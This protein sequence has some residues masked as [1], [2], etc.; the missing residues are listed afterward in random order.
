MQI[1]GASVAKASSKQEKT[2]P[3]DPAWTK[4]TGLYRSRGG[5]SAVV[6]RNRELVEF[7]PTGSTPERPNK[8]VPI[9][10]GEF[11]FEAA[12]GGGVV[13]EVVRF[14]EQPNGKMRMY[15]GGSYSE[16]VEP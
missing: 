8:L 11:R 3:W 10:N 16:R 1:V 13:G 12:T 4:F 14:V 6:E 9:G 5:D 15:R 7:D 2:I